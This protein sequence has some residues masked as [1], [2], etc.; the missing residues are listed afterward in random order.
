MIIRD[1]LLLAT[2]TATTTVT[3]SSSIV[4][5][6]RPPQRQTFCPR[7]L[8]GPYFCFNSNRSNN[9]NHNHRRHCPHNDQ[10]VWFIIRWNYR[11]R[12][13]Y[14]SYLPIWKV[15]EDKILPDGYRVGSRSVSTI[16]K[17]LP[18]R[19]WRRTF[20]NRNS[21]RSSGSCTF[22]DL[23]RLSQVRKSVG[24]GIQNFVSRTRRYAWRWDG[25]RFP[26]TDGVK[27]RLRKGLAPAAAVVELVGRRQQG[28]YNLP[29]RRQR[30]R[31]AKS[32]DFF[33]LLRSSNCQAQQSLPNR[34]QQLLL[35]RWLRKKIPSRRVSMPYP[36]YP[37][38]RYLVLPQ[39]SSLLP[40]HQHHQCWMRPFLH[41]YRLPE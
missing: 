22:T 41:S 4:G 21:P 24:I 26:S 19:S 28:K 27:R 40:I 25:I 14:I 2:A 31:P 3:C 12:T 7:L 34:R 30:H 37:Q 17:F 39:S 11:S 18:K 13:N 38:Y 1:L 35:L 29:R 32:F 23:P 15:W 20:D 36:I 5:S 8:K 10:R 6:I 16:Q 9:I 33:H